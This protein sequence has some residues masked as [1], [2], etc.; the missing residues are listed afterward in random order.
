[1]P[2]PTPW[3]WVAPLAVKVADEAQ[4]V[5]LVTKAPSFSPDRLVLVSADAP[6]GSTVPPATMP[7]PLASQPEIRV[8]E[9]APG[10]YTLAITGLAQAGVL[11]VSENW[12]PW[13]TA[14]VDGAPAPIA[15]ANGA[16]LG[17]EVPAGAREVRLHLDSRGDARGL[18]ASL[19]GAGA[20]LLLA[21]SGLLS[22]RAPAGAAASE[23]TA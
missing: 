22:R 12:M 19:A 3:A 14:T 21:L 18:Q 8:T 15:R 10:D 5:Q 7:E 6:F 13:W 20:L 11:V 23:A 1:V 9:G 16:F 2:N 17:I 4:V